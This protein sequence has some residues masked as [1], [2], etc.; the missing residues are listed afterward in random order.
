MIWEIYEAR[1][2]NKSLIINNINVYSKYQPCKDAELW[3]DSNY[4]SN[5]EA[6][7]LIGLGLGY[8][9]E[10]LL[11]KDNSKKV[12]VYYLYKEEMFIFR[13]YGKVKCANKRVKFKWIMDGITNFSE[14]TQLL[15]PSVWIQTLP[16]TNG[17]IKDYLDIIKLKQNSYRNSEESMIINFEN[18]TRCFNTVFTPQKVKNKKACLV[19]AGPSLSQ[20]VK[21]LKNINSHID[22]YVV[23]TALKFIEN[24]NIRPKGVFHSD[25]SI[26]N[27]VQFEN[28]EFKG[29]LYY[30][31]TSNN[32]VVNNHAG[33]KCIVFQKG[34]DLSEGYAKSYS[35]PLVETGGSVATLGFSIIEALGY[36][37]LV[38]FGQDLSFQKEN[39]HIIES[40]SNRIISS[41][42]S[43]LIVSN[44]GE[45][46]KTTLGMLAF[47]YWFEKR[48]KKT[49]MKVY[50]TSLQGAKIKYTE[51]INEFEFKNWA[52]N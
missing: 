1:D 20:T 5:Y 19:S 46:V 52:E 38:L 26:S 29:K 13:R 10:A 12:T 41:E 15:V 8:H 23:G 22:I 37:E 33:E 6:Y 32:K 47:L 31:S 11:K 39:T 48:F 43:R 28:T 49:E 17:K 24:N 51:M 16:P 42:N 14:N 45:S 4:N 25:P 7:H 3:I 35:Y 44:S 50:N 18:N 40:T 21:W 2:R 36:E 9:L 34:Y 30:L 27:L